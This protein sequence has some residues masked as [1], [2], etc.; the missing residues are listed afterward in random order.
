MENVRQYRAM[1]SLCRLQAT[2]D[3]ANAFRW[4]A[5]AD[6]WEYLVEAEIEDHYRACNADHDG[7]AAA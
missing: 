2:L 3:P 6:R 4:L 7:L 1:A 5:H